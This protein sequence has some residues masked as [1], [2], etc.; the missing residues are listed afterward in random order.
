MEIKPDFILFSNVLHEVENHR[1]FLDCAAGSKAVCV[2]EWKKE[3]TGFGPSVK[4][5][6][7][8]AEM[9]L[10]LKK[11]FKFV[12]KFKIY[13]YH[14]LLVGYHNRNIWNSENK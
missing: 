8:R 4:Y 6:I 7:E 14:Y 1:N 11:R 2:I 10:A 9:E 13:P 5:R 12:K 3:E